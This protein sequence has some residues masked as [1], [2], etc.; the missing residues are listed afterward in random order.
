[1]K[2]KYSNCVVWQIAILG[3]YNC[4]L[5]TIDLTFSNTSAGVVT[6]NCL[7]CVWIKRCWIHYVTS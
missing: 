6:Q 1:M 4:V 2:T 5:T 3:V 7:P